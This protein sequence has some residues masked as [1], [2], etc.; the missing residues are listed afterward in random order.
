MFRG[1]LNRLL[2]IKSF[3]KYVIRKKQF[4][5]EFVKDLN[6]EQKEAVIRSY[7]TCKVPTPPVL[8]VGPYGTGKTYTVAKAVHYVLAH[9]PKARILIAS[10]SNRYFDT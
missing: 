8:I 6:S 10:N 1:I 4:D 9:Q 7:F 2:S 3:Y 5:V